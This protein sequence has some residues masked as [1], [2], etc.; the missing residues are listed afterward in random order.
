MIRNAS[1]QS[2]K[3]KKIINHNT[4]NK[5]AVQNKILLTLPYIHTVE[6]HL[7]KR[8]MSNLFQ[9]LKILKYKNLPQNNIYYHNIINYVV[10]QK[11][12]KTYIEMLINFLIYWA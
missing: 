9:K 4:Y 10:K 12:G 6:W 2:C 7:K 11:F 5:K 8:K 1:E 3:H